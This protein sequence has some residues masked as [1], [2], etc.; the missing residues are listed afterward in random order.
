MQ[1]HSRPPTCDLFLFNAHHHMVGV[2]SAVHVVHNYVYVYTSFAMTM[3]RE[4]HH[5]DDQEPTTGESAL[6]QTEDYVSR[7]LQ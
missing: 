1:L 4:R 7:D 3:S 2:A 6:L 5:V